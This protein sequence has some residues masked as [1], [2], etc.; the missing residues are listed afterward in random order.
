MKVKDTVMK[1][2]PLEQKG[3]PKIAY[4]IKCFPR[5]SETFIMHEVLELEHQGVPLRIFSLLRP[6][7]KINKASEEVQATVTYVPNVFPLALIP[8]LL[9]SG[10]RFFK[11][12]LKFLWVWLAALVRFHHHA[13]PRH[14][15]YAAYIANQLEQEGITHVHAHY[16]NTPTTVAL[17]AHQM[18]GIPFSFTA[19]A[20]DIYLSRKASLIYKMSNAQFVVTCTG[21]NQQ[22]L[23]SLMEGQKPV[24][25]HRIYHGLNLRVFP[26][27]AHTSSARPLIL[28]VA[29]LV[30]KKGLPYLLDACR[31]LKNQGYDFTCRIVGDGEL[32]PVLE[33]R[34]RDLELSDTVELSGA[35]TH[36]RVIET[37]QQATMFALP[38]IVGENGD[39]DGIPNVLVEAL[40]M[41]V[42]VVSTPISG[43]PELLTDEENGLLVPSRNSS[44]L[45]VSMARLLDDGLLRRR[46][47][48]SGRQTVMSHFDMRHNA[49]RL[50]GLLLDQA[51]ALPSFELNNPNQPAKV[52]SRFT[53][54]SSV[55]LGA[56]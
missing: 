32:R 42:P 3:E 19:H 11:S 12:P 24:D 43:I 10:K 56:R 38:C 1:Y 33:E 54:P 48:V 9:A 45:A 22:Y 2:T 31:I 29:R 40:Y 30:E 34:I 21:Y 6:S 14:L 37:Y 26:P 53:L 36:E 50:K 13:T 23:S 55:E 7:G 25:I 46:L 17:L 4:L 8:L 49:Q 39:R 15:L 47:A 16:A 20:K 27:Q 44:A 41:G 18:T 51:Y 35:E 28:T 52:V 5:L